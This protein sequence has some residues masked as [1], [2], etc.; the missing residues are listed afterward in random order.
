AR[1]RHRRRK[2]SIRP[3]TASTPGESRPSSSSFK[4]RL[5]QQRPKEILESRLMRS[6][7]TPLLMGALASAFCA[8]G[9]SGQGV[10]GCWGRRKPIGFKSVWELDFSRTYNR[11]FEDK[12]T[13]ASGKAPRP[14]LINIWYPTKEP[15]HVRPMLHREYLAI[16]SRD[17]RL[18]R[19]ATELVDYERSV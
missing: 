9:G 16:E 5:R 6:I 15:D 4:A 2:C 14:I 12:T 17:P 18:T 8:S 1:R 10:P 19:F 11:V 3:G 13:Y 7:H